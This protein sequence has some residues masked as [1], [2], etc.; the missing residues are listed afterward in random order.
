MSSSTNQRQQQRL[1]VIFTPAVTQD[2]VKRAASLM[3]TVIASVGQLRVGMTDQAKSAGYDSRVMEKFSDM[4]STIQA[5]E[6][7]LSDVRH[8]CNKISSMSRALSNMEKSAE[9]LRNPAKTRD[10]GSKKE[11][12]DIVDNMIAW[13]VHERHES[14]HVLR[15]FGPQMPPNLARELDSVSQQS[16]DVIPQTPLPLRH[17]STSDTTRSGSQSQSQSQLVVLEADSGPTAVT[18]LK[19]K[20]SRL[21]DDNKMNEREC[22]A[23]KEHIKKLQ[24]ELEQGQESA[25]RLELQ[26]R[27]Q[28][29][30]SEDKSEALGRENARLSRELQAARDEQSKAVSYLTAQVD[31]LKAQIY[32]L[33]AGHEF[34]PD[35]NEN[36]RE[37]L[38]SALA[39]AEADKQALET[40]NQAIVEAEKRA[41]DEAKRGAEMEIHGLKAEL[42]AM[43]RATSIWEKQ[44]TDVVTK[45]TSERM[46]H[47][48]LARQLNDTKDNL[49][50]AEYQRRDKGNECM[51]L[52]KTIDG[53]GRTIHT[54]RDKVVFLLQESFGSGQTEVLWDWSEVAL[55]ILED[56]SL[57][58]SV[59]MPWD[60]QP[61]TI[62]AS[63][64]GAGAGA[65]GVSTVCWTTLNVVRQIKIC[66]WSNVM[67]PG[68]ECLVAVQAA[69]LAA[70]SDRDRGIE[71]WMLRT[72]DRALLHIASQLRPAFVIRVA[73][74]QLL[75]IMEARWP[76]ANTT[77]VSL[78]TGPGFGTAAIDGGGGH[79]AVQSVMNGLDSAQREV[80]VMICFDRDIPASSRAAIRCA[81]CG[82]DGG[83]VIATL[84]ADAEQNTQVEGVLLGLS[85]STTGMRSLRWVSAEKITL[86]VSGVVFDDGPMGQGQLTVPY[87]PE[88]ML[89][90]CQ[91]LTHR[92]NFVL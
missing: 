80:L 79:E 53:L 26:T 31:G 81:K 92:L 12:Q 70:A 90:A 43:S 84:A 60:F 91:F 13:L 48:S 22:G 18:E 64:D 16:P 23:L 45:L 38:E 51:D 69:I 71:R 86:A 87:T 40:A 30:L 41:F 88:V 6:R 35:S 10:A 27:Q 36:N 89:W 3:E 73:I 66:D 5:L 21:R 78:L 54:Y 63:R 24:R 39:D 74:V 58:P 8:G 1:A 62:L 14:V 20:I 59:D 29:Q 42:Q 56:L 2:R 50:Q 49:R 75:R 61:W 9:K 7:T 76:T 25:K 15:S 28:I 32:S 33:T 65:T 37:K 11:T 52:A 77:R 85:S 72:L 57:E 55:D 19:G 47:I 67:T 83:A 46:A 4:K 17:R 44:H 34:T 68:F 82:L